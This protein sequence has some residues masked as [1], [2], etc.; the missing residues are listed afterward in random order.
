MKINRLLTYILLI[1]AL[2]ASSLY[3]S[4]LSLKYSVS[5]YPTGKIKENRLKS[6]LWGIALNGGGALG[7]AHLGALKAFE[8]KGLVPDMMTGTS[9]GAI[10]GGFIAAGYD[11][12]EV[13]DLMHSTDFAEMFLYSP[14]RKNLN[15]AGKTDHD[16]FMGTLNISPQGLS[17]PQSLLPDYGVQKLLFTYL[18]TVSIMDGLDD[19]NRLYYPFRAVAAD[20]KTGKGY[21]WEKGDLGLAVRTSMNIPGVF[22]PIRHEGM[23]LV[24][25][26][27]YHN[28]PSEELRAMGVDFVVGVKFNTREEKTRDQTIINTLTSVISNFISEKEEEAYKYADII[29]EVPLQGYSSA[30]FN[31]YN[32]IYEKGYEYASKF[33]EQIIAK[34]GLEFRKH[35]IR[36]LDVGGERVAV[37]AYM[38]EPEMYE[39]IE[40]HLKKDNIYAYEAELDDGVLRV[41][42]TVSIENIRIYS[43]DKSVWYDTDNLGEVKSLLDTIRRMY[44]YSGERGLNVGMT[45][46]REGT[47]T[48]MTSVIDVD[49][50]RVENNKY[51]SES[52]IRSIMGYT[53]GAKLDKDFLHS[54]DVLY[55]TGKFKSV[56]PYF[57]KS[58]EGNI[59]VLNVTEKEQAL[60]KFTGSY[61]SDRGLLTFMQF[62][63]NDFL[64]WGDYAGFEMGLSRDLNLRVFTGT[65]SLW[66]GPLGVRAYYAFEKNTYFPE[67]GF[68]GK[69]DAFGLS[70][71]VS[72]Y[73]AGLN[74]Y[75]ER[76]RLDEYPSGE[77]RYMKAGVT[78]TTDLLND[79]YIPTDGVRTFFNYEKAFDGAGYQRLSAKAE[80]CVS[81]GP[82]LSLN[83]S[84]YWGKFYGTD[85]VYNE[86]IYYENLFVNDDSAYYDKVCDVRAG[87]KFTGIDKYAV[88]FVYAGRIEAG[89]GAAGKYYYGAGIE[90]KLILLKYIRWEY[91][92]GEGENEINFMIGAKLP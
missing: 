21:V 18:S 42:N 20:I 63:Y 5:I 19:F 31:K 24:D 84:A 15:P 76:V 82:S 75:G 85:R 51:I 55:A 16:L 11:I 67:D 58:P 69:K 53:D 74:I 26:G 54:L 47:L 44:I 80:G 71:S 56:V 30:S 1:C 73:F 79:A 50:L 40:S 17:V 52:K 45:E 8:E 87:L 4:E 49:G 65:S 12:E 46:F 92:F 37:K 23:M 88:P 70:A 22:P 25:G 83:A 57:E 28:F 9:M 6:R 59:C 3:G 10:M 78:H 66:G 43:P 72:R 90:Q 32:E 62:M 39:L 64:R 48:I 33:T 41:V 81:I 91:I 38:M 7:F 61:M 86:R 14:E 89:E 34:I 2:S 29:I 60:M 36:E 35:Y 27:I 13:T 77:R 68:V